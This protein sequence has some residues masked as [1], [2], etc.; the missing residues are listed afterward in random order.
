MTTGPR[1]EV[2]TAVPDELAEPL[3]LLEE[4]LR[5]G[6]PVP[7]PLAGRLARAVEGG[8]LEVLAARS[9]G[10]VV[11][12]A[13]LS[14]RPNVSLG[15]IFASI[16]DL[17]VRPEMRRRGVGRALLG[18]VEDLCRARGVSYVEVQT[19]S[20]AALFYEAS[21]YETEADVRVLSRSYAL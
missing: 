21:G 8:D 7:P 18:A 6:E 17:Y 13:V 3:A 10:R 1:I 16:E 15:A 4:S 9:D 20:Q 19:D 5:N 11:A 14:L 12:V 2:R